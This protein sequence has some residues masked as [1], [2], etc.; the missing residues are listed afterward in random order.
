MADVNLFIIVL[1]KIY[2]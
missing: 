2:D 1:R